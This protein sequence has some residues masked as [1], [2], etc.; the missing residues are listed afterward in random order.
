MPPVRA[1]LLLNRIAN[2]DLPSR[3]A[4]LD[5]V[6]AFHQRLKAF[7]YPHIFVDAKLGAMDMEKV[8]HQD[9]APP[10]THFQLRALAAALIITAAILL[11]QRLR[12]N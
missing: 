12:P 11:S 6:R 10:T 1:T 9:F 5:S 7:F 2:T 8:P 3:L 4:Y